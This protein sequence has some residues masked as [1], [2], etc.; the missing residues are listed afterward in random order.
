M[1][2]RSV[3]INF[4]LS[5]LLFTSCIEDK[6]S[7]SNSS[8]NR[9]TKSNSAITPAAEKPTK[10]S[11]KNIITKTK[12]ETLLESIKRQLIYIDDHFSFNF[13]LE[14][15]ELKYFDLE[16]AKKTEKI[17]AAIIDLQESEE[18]DLSVYRSISFDLVSANL[19]NEPVYTNDTQDQLFIDDMANYDTVRFALHF[20][21]L[22][23]EYKELKETNAILANQLKSKTGFTCEIDDDYTSKIA[24]RWLLTRL[25]NSMNT[26]KGI[27]TIKRLKNIQ[28]SN[29]YS[30]SFEGTNLDGIKINIE[31]FESYFNN[32]DTRYGILM[33]IE[34]KVTYLE[35]TLNTTIKYKGLSQDPQET[36]EIIN[37]LYKEAKKPGAQLH[38]LETIIIG[39]TNKFNPE[40][41]MIFLE[42]D[43]DSERDK[44]TFNEAIDY[45]NRNI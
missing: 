30:F 15:W 13:H 34:K 3:L 42:L 45:Y 2:P 38:G 4:L 28:I 9:K 24:V 41:D 22:S 44:K 27:E 20:H 5:A 10:K 32:T 33:D 7:H 18:I 19:D 40:L 29:H 6:K 36:Y 14:S 1:R 25:L 23:Q 26:E 17:L 31:E 11:H 43:E 12:L 8:K 35:E 37:T 21:P 39:I 16:K